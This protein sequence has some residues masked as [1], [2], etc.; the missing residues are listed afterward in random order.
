MR[1][2]RSLLSC[3]T[4]VL[5]ACAQD[6]RLPRVT[7]EEDRLVLDRR[8][9]EAR[10][11]VAALG[12][13]DLMA[14][15]TATL[16]DRTRI[17]RQPSH[18][19]YAE[20]TS[21]D[22][23]VWMWYRGNAATVRGTWAVVYHTPRPRVCFRYR[24]SPP[25]TVVEY[26]PEECIEPWEII[27]PTDMV[28]ERPGDPF[29]LATGGVPY[30]KSSDDV[31]RWPAL[32]AGHDTHRAE[33]HPWGR[34]SPSWRRNEANRAPRIRQHPPGAFRHPRS[35]V[36][37]RTRRRNRDSAMYVSTLWIEPNHGVLAAATR[38]EPHSNDR[39]TLYDAADRRFDGA[40]HG[41]SVS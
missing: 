34:R 8:V 1:T 7:A 6:P 40:N 20:Y 19:V 21:A 26:V 36:P 12:D 32:R 38:F 3:L 13:D 37:V 41:E 16:T 10:D 17:F 22:G 23:T 30:T 25:G 39:A 9:M 28:D 24:E 31:P 35:R 27:A 2:R 14:L 15:L 11:R 4:L 33:V 18:G 29:R 5:S